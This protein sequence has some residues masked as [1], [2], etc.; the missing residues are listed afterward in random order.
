MTTTSTLSELRIW[1]DTPFCGAPS[2][3]TATAART[4]LSRQLAAAI[5]AADL[6][7][8]KAGTRTRVGE[9][10]IA[11][12]G[13]SRERGDAACAAAE[14]GT[15]EWRA[16]LGVPEHATLTGDG[17]GANRGAWCTCPNDE[18]FAE[19][20]IR[21]EH[22]TAAGCERHGFVHSTCRRLLQTG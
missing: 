6:L 9:M 15:P 12:A 1:W 13:W 21:Y 16:A 3:S 2:D 17:Q 8:E 11:S 22:W 4:A 14:P 20:W 18:V 19:Q 10:F 5:L 7:D